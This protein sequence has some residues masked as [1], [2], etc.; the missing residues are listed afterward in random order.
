MPSP[1]GACVG[2]VI[3]AMNDGG[4]NLPDLRQRPQAAVVVDRAERLQKQLAIA[5]DVGMGVVL[6]SARG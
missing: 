3:D 6:V 4:V 1:A 5:L 2:A